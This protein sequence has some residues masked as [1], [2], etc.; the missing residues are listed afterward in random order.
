MIKI[1]C[2]LSEVSDEYHTFAE[3]YEHRNLL[4]LSFLHAMHGYKAWKSCLH[5]DGSSYDGWFIVGTE[6]AGKQISYHLPSGLWKYTSFITEYERAPVEWDGH[7]SNDVLDR[8]KALLLE[9]DSE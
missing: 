5:H 1:N 7:T 4:Y 2:S 9:E 3:L 8:L 6:I